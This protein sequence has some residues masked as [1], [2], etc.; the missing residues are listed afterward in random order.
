MN[1]YTQHSSICMC[2]CVCDNDI[3][4]WEYKKKRSLCSTIYSRLACMQSAISSQQHRGRCLKGWQVVL[5]TTKTHNSFP[6]AAA[7]DGEGKR[8]HHTDAVALISLPF[9]FLLLLKTKKRK[10][11]K[12][13]TM[14][15]LATE[16]PSPGHHLLLFSF[17]GFVIDFALMTLLFFFFFF[18][19]GS[20]Q[21]TQ[22]V[23]RS[24]RKTKHKS[25]V[26][27]F[28]FI[29]SCYTFCLVVSL[30]YF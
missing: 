12:Y 9:F 28:L 16:T 24:G 14:S 11:E 20:Q 25:R 22:K 2:V 27:G 15:R 21:K 7:Q 29:F 5:G 13:S 19:Q 6:S 30:L 17:L 1:I 26:W 4:R 10:M 8:Y 18:S 3:W 23:R